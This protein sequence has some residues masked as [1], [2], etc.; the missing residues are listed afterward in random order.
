MLRLIL[1]SDQ[2]SS[3]WAHFFILL[4]LALGLRLANLIFSKEKGQKLHTRA[5]SSRVDRTTEQLNK[6]RYR[7]QGAPHFWS[8]KWIFWAHGP[9]KI[10]W[11]RTTIPRFYGPMVFPPCG[12]DDSVALHHWNH[13]EQWEMLVF[14]PASLSNNYLITLFPFKGKRK[15]SDRFFLLLLIYWEFHFGF[16]E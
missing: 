10:L 5:L 15:R 3:P 7:H 9:Q 1:V 2:R 6:Y 12:Q 13:C 8:G 16:M 11:T 14:P 4:F